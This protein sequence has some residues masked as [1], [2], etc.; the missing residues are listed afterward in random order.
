MDR[1]AV[2]SCPIR[3]FVVEDEWLF[4]EAVVGTLVNSSEFE[5]GGQARDGET[6]LARMLADPPDIA[7]V[8]IESPGGLELCA[9]LY[10]Q[11]SETRVVVFTVSRRPEDL[12]AALAVG[13]SGFLVKQDTH[14][15]ER[16]LEALRIVAD[17]GMLLPGSVTRQLLLELAN[18]PP[19]DP[20]AKYG[21]TARE[22]DVL[23]LLAEGGTNLEIANELSITVQAVKNHLRNVFRKL[24]VTNRTSAAVLARREGLVTARPPLNT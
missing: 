2:L 21:L 17:G 19:D 7:L 10:E 12:Q 6:A 11:L 15:P 5:I 24:D 1:S 18:R 3:V 8:D 14:A 13:V 22:R 23:A 9:H 20:V 4:S 16:L